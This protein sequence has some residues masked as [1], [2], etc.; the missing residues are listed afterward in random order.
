[1]S[2]SKDDNVFNLAE[3]RQGKQQQR[4]NQDLMQG[5]GRTGEC[6]D[7]DMSD[8]SALSQK[9]VLV[10]VP[11]HLSRLFGAKLVTALQEK[12]FTAQRGV[13]LPSMSTRD[14]IDLLEGYTHFVL[15]KSDSS[16]ANMALISGLLESHM[17]RQRMRLIVF[18]LKGSRIHR[19]VP[20]I[21]DDIVRLWT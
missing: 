16:A 10:I 3:W 4:R 2:G 19:S 7:E 1:M 21:L 18:S 12:G 6:W 5:R 15:I 13:L 17:V 20:L 9:R 11:S 14:A 8:A